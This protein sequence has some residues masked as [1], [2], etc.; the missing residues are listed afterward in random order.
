MSRFVL[1]SKFSPRIS[2]KCVR[3]QHISASKLFL[4]EFGDPAKVVKK[5][6]FTLGV[7]EM[8]TSQVI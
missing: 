6:D 2:L 4:D 5:E 7:P 3:H 8:R 1:F